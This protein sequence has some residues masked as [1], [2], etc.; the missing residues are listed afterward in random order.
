VP[1][2]ALALLAQF[3]NRDHTLSL[4]RLFSDYRAPLIALAVGG[5]IV[6]VIGHLIQSKTAIVCGILL[7]FVALVAFP[8]VL[9]VRG[10]P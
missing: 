4:E 8:V 3:S 6:A 7:V 5:F 9:Y 2:L 10:G 1:V